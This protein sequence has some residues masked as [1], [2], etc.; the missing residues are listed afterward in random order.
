MKRQIL[1]PEHDAFRETVRTVL[2]EEVLPYYE[3]WE[4]Y[5]I[6]LSAP[7]EYRVA[8]AFTDG[9]IRP[10]AAGPPRS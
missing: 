8:G 1:A 9:R 3:Q 7:P 2:A 4:K 6:A 5:G 10:T